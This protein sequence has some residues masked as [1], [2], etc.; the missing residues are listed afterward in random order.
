MFLFNNI[1]NRIYDAIYKTETGQ[2]KV[3]FDLTQNQIRIATNEDW[4]ILDVGDLCCVINSDRKFSNIFVIRE[5]GY[6]GICEDYVIRGDLVA[7]ETLHNSPPYVLMARQ[8]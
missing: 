6:S 4:N 7:K 1:S 8:V 3:L 2:S 5:K